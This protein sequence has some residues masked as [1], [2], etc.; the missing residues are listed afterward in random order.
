MFNA[1][2]RR[3]AAGTAV[4]T[5][6]TGVLLAGALTAGS[7]AATAAKNVPAAGAIQ[8][9]S[10]TGDRVLGTVKLTRTSTV[11]WSST[12]RRFVLTDTSRK[13]KISGKT[14]SGQ[15]FAARGSYRG[16]RVQAKGRWTLTIKPLPAPKP[17]R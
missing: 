8:R 1:R 12:G 15:T 11:R 7:T 14:K 16:V 6:L 17:K 4:I 10:G 5:T 3:R 2:M 9:W 13:L